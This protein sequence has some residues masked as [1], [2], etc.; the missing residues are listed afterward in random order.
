MECSI[1]FNRWWSQAW[2]SHKM[3]RTPPKAMYEF[4]KLVEIRSMA[5]L[6]KFVFFQK[7][8]SKFFQIIFESSP[9]N[10]L[11]FTRVF[12][13]FWPQVWG[14]PGSPLSDSWLCRAQKGFHV[15]MSTGLLFPQVNGVRFEHVIRARALDVLRRATHLSITVRVNLLGYWE[16]RTAPVASPRKHQHHRNSQGD[17]LAQNRLSSSDFD[18]MDYD[19]PLSTPTTGVQA[20]QGEAKKSFMTLNRPKSGIRKALMKMNIIS[21]DLPRYGM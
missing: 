8:P 19:S 18:S 7:K 11:E 20:V 21:K 2:K 5:Q 14:L 9:N 1:V 16:M 4:E 6:R 17:L 15:A 10:F 3:Y 12:S 13:L